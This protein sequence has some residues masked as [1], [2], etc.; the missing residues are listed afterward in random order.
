MS[1]A[2]ALAL[3][4]PDFVSDRHPGTTRALEQRKRQFHYRKCRIRADTK[5][6]WA[7]SGDATVQR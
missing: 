6:L 3:T 7:H 5:G 4:S 1:L 2:V